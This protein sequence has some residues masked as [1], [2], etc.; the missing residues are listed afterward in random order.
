MTSPRDVIIVGAGPA[1]VGMATSLRQ[2]GIQDVLVIDRYE[3]GSSF[4]RWPA[5]TVF[6]TPSFYANPFGAVDLNAIS[7]DSSVALSSGREHPGGVAYAEYLSEVLAD[8][9]IPT[10]L[11]CHV[12]Q[13]LLS[14]NGLYR[15]VTSNGE[16]LEC[17]AL[18]WAT[19]E[20]QFPERYVFDGS[21]LCCHYA[22]VMRWH[23]V[24]P[25]EYVI[26]GGYES[27]VDAT[28]NLIN[29]GSKVKMLT[30]SAPLAAGRHTTDPSLTLSPFSQARLEEALKNPSLEIHVNADVCN[31]RK[32]PGAEGGYQI[33]SR[34][35]RSWLSARQPFL[36]TGFL[37]GGGARQIHSFFEWNNEGYPV[38][39][40][41]D[42]STLF[43][44]LYMVGPQVRHKDD[45]FCF[46]YK[47]RER[48]SVVAS[49]IADHLKIFHGRALY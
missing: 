18:I 25:A 47:F 40:K 46:I 30:R 17:K 9:Q 37:S 48:F 14:S 45:I 23:D 15:L 3:V 24:K 16:T 33:I 43:K 38:L 36:C 8:H 39:T 4:L 7:S 31:V 26:I 21:E 32:N 13:V 44:G 35:G 12:D 49:A 11:F 41:N 29:N 27:A 42:A 1:G 10:L 22:D 28:V 34:D 2:A 5:E 19:G 20:F 6:I